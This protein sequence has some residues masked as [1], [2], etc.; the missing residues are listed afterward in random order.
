MT[1]GWGFG[2][3]SEADSAL[4]AWVNAGLLAFI[5]LAPLP[6]ASNRPLPAAML[7]LSAG[8]LLI[9]WSFSIWRGAAIAIAPSRIAASLVLYL[10]V[11]LWIGFQ[12]MPGPWA[13]PMWAEASAALGT[14]LPG[15]ISVNPEASLTGLMHLLC[16]GGVFWLSLQLNAQVERAYLSLRVIAAIGAAYAL[17]GLIVW[18]AGNEWILV[19]RKW[20]YPHSLTSSFVNRNSFATYMGLCLLPAFSLFIKR[21]EPILGTRRP[22]RQ[23]IV[24]V[25]EGLS[26]GTTAWFGGTVLV[27]AL[28]LLLTESRAGVFSSIVALLAL[29]LVHIRSKLSRRK[30]LP[31]LALGT[32]FLGVILLAG[33][34][35]VFNRYAETTVLGSREGIYLLTL[36]AIEA[37]PW[38][39]SGFGTFPDVISAF[40]PKTPQLE[41]IWDKAHNTYLENALELGV[42]AAIALNA[43]IL[44]LAGIALRGVQIRKRDWAIAGIG[45]A[46]TVLVGLHALV[47][48]S[49]QIPAV[50]VLYAFMLG[51]AV[52]QS[53]STRRPG[54]DSTP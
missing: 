9:G 46:A 33:G 2:L 35:T 7:A 52:A 10:S 51:I 22:W 1:D 15:R 18:I 8:I 11:C 41:P 26:S 38:T 20:A 34:A 13:D 47:D 3:K 44:L 6:L 17:Y 29:A 28:A 30:I 24:L 16:Y 45:I 50:A 36:D 14:S 40:Q 31:T 53:W 19:Y 49:L 4:L 39:G 23:K 12:W 32:T 42:P 43:A 48:F 27:I 54:Q 21:I 5:A 25:L 37:S